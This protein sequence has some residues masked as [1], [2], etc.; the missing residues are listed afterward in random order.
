MNW[1][2]GMFEEDLARWCQGCY[3][4]LGFNVPLDWCQGAY[5]AKNFMHK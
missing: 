2:E 5:T 1:S 3:G 4:I